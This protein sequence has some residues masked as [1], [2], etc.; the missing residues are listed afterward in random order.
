MTTKTTMM[1][2]TP[3]DILDL[4][5]DGFLLAF[6]LA[7]TATAWETVKKNAK[8]VQAVGFMD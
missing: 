3:S 5:L 4:D 6:D 2:I 7:A 1:I 8:S